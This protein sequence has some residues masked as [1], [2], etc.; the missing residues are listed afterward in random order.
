M[1]RVRGCPQAE[2][3][4]SYFHTF[5]PSKWLPDR[6]SMHP[7]PQAENLD[8]G[9]IPEFPLSKNDQFSEFPYN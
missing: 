7:S 8:A 3:L 6:Q 1:K 4:P 9:V 5:V 2:N